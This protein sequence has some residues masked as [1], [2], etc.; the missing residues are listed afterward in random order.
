MP[1]ILWMMYRHSLIFIMQ[2][3]LCH[4][5]EISQMMKQEP[6]EGHGSTRGSIV[7]VSSLAGINASSGMSTYCASKHSIVGFAKTDAQDY[8]PHGI[9]V[10]VVCPGM[11]DT[12][13]FRATSPPDAPAALAAITPVRRLGKPSDVAWLAA[14]LCSA[15]SSFIHGAV[16]PCDGGLSLQRGII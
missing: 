2:T 16:I 15:E 14:F 11:I 13:L 8:G 1:L 5:A 6:L 4:Q 10:N 7:T 12:D 9:R 3:W